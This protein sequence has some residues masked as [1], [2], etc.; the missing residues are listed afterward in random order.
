[1][2]TVTQII[3]K[4]LVQRFPQ[5]QS[6]LNLWNATMKMGMV[7]LLNMVLHQRATAL[8]SNNSMPVKS[9][10]ELGRPSS[11]LFEKDSAATFSES[12]P[13]Y[14]NIDHFSRNATVTLNLLRK[15][16]DFMEYGTKISRADVED[17]NLIT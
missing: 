4:K 14:Y 10:H 6:D 15:C 1:F 17:M 3:K 16:F 9:L 12:G 7:R 13:S 8:I 2:D 11:E 5:F